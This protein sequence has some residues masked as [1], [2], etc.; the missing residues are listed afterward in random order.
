MKNFFLISLLIF[1]YSCGYTSVYKNLKNQDF[2]ITVTEMIGDR[3]MNNL[4]KNELNLYS[5]KNSI[6]EINITLDTVYGKSVLAKNSK[7]EATD[8]DIFITSSIIISSN[9]NSQ[10]ITLSENINIKKQTDSFEQDIYEKNIKRNF[11]SVIREKLITKI[12]SLK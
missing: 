5:N 8:Y 10:K 4:I 11:A 12:I 3:E 6:N 1:I 7:G 9:K 2:Q